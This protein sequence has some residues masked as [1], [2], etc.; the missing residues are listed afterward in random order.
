[1]WI[2]EGKRQLGRPKCRKKNNIKMD[3]SEMGW[4]G[5]DWIDLAKDK[6]E[7][8]CGSKFYYIRVNVFPD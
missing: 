4:E 6:D 3:I 5:M 7:C 2:P 8:K 1:V